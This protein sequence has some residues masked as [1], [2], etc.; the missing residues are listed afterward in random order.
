MKWF[1]PTWG[2]PVCEPDEQAPTP[3]GEHCLACGGTIRDMDQGFII[4]RMIQEGDDFID[5]APSYW[6]LNCFLRNIGVLKEK[7]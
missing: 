6:H 7:P 5:F 1:G 2:A 4:P 3:V